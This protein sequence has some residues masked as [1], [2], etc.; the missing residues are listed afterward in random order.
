MPSSIH[1]TTTTMKS[2]CCIIHPILVL[3]TTTLLLQLLLLLPPSCQ[4]FAAAKNKKVTNRKKT[5][6]STRKGFGAQAPTFAQ[7]I[8]GLET[9][10]P[11]DPR[12]TPCPCGGGGSVENDKVVMYADCCQPYHAGT[13]V[14]ETP[15]R[16]LQS[17]YSV[18]YF[19]VIPYIM[20]TTH[21]T[22][23]YWRKDAV[24]WA[25]QLDQDGTMD[26]FDF[27]G[28]TIV[29]EEQNSAVADN[30]KTKGDTAVPDPNQAQVEFRVRVRNKKD[31]EET[32]LK[33]KSLFVKQGD[34]WFYASGEAR[35]EPVLKKQAKP[36]QES[37]SSS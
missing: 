3:L 20:L 7:V 24:K 30:D 32:V 31:G 5:T 6:A 16:V 18:F 13:K 27:L 33:E 2:R 22:C 1:P 34:R 35:P 4:A 8:S 9:R 10:L 23:Q 28:L 26:T 21:P 12:T 15:L 19:R 25:Q 29:G 17:R 14:A 11:E 37:S 36:D